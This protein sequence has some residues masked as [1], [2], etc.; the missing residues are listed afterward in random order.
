M[1][2][3]RVRDGVW[4]GLSM[5]EV[6]C[7]ERG[8]KSKTSRLNNLGVKPRTFRIPPQSASRHLEVWG[9]QSAEARIKVDPDPGLA[10]NGNK[11]G[12][13]EGSFTSRGQKSR[14]YKVEGLKFSI[15]ELY[16]VERQKCKL[17]LVFLVATSSKTIENCCNPASACQHQQ[18]LLHQS[19]PT[20]RPI[21]YPITL[22]CPQMLCGV[23]DNTSPG[24]FS[25]PCAQKHIGTIDTSSG[26]V[27]FNVAKSSVSRSQSRLK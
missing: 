19:V 17:S 8:Y 1:E 5:R 4:N 24:A 3:D 11:P 23:I 9:S 21:P 14:G 27:K 22:P 26:T 6:N 7:Y 16:V 2:T 15:S 25:N 20:N 13:K 10:G 12:A 18:S